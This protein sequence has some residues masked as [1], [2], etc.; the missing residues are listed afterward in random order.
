VASGLGAIAEDRAAAERLW[1]LS[2]RLG[3]LDGDLPPAAG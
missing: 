2:A 1:R 3:G